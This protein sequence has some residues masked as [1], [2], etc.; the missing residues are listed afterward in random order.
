MADPAK[1]IRPRLTIDDVELIVN[2]L[3]ERGAGTRTIEELEAVTDLTARLQR[4]ASDG[5]F[6]TEWFER[7]WG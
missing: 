6:R 2:A 3:E 7:R 4:S 5:P 1:V